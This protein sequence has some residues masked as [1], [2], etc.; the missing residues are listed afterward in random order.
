MFYDAGKTA[1][2]L[3][4]GLG[5]VAGGL[6][7]VAL[8]LLLDRDLRDQLLTPHTPAAAPIHPQVIQ[9]AAKIAPL[10][11]GLDPKESRIAIGAL[12]GTG[13]SQLAQTLAKQLGMKHHDADMYL[14]KAPIPKGS[15]AERYDMLVNEDPE[16]F[17]ALLHLRRPGAGRGDEMSRW[18]D[19]PAVDKANQAQFAAAKGKEL[20]PTSTAWLKLKPAGGFGT[21]NLDQG[22]INKSHVAKKAVPGLLGMVAGTIAAHLLKK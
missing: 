19:L 7:A 16:Q 17:D 13:K 2:A 6:G 9:D 22:F 15:I 4:Y 18:L 1:A 3:H 8:Q 10:L 12:P 21:K 20:H 5:A 14:G 11:K